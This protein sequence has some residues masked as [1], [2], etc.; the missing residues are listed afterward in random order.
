MTGAR[1][2]TRIMRTT[3]GLIGFVA[4]NVGGTTRLS[5]PLGNEEKMSEPTKEYW[6]AKAD[7]CKATALK[8]LEDL[9]SYEAMKNLERM[10]YALSRVGIEN[11]REANDE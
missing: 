3:T 6:Q 8:Q 9:N 2:R 1:Q 4:T 5:T 7:L 10:V 11:K